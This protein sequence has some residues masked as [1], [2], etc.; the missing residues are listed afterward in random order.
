MND[1]RRLPLL[2]LQGFV[3]VSRFQSSVPN[4]ANKQRSLSILRRADRFIVEP[5]FLPRERPAAMA[6]PSNRS[7]GH[8][9][10]S[11]RTF[12][13]GDL[14]GHLPNFL[15]NQMIRHAGYNDAFLEKQCALQ[16]QRTLIM[17]ELMP[18]LRRNKFRKHNCDDVIVARSFDAIDIAE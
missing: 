10:T 17:K 14:A 5:A 7:P 8:S 13:G 6:Y 2:N 15:L 18:P 12:P 16:E 3:S 11:T 1:W 9:K 4:A